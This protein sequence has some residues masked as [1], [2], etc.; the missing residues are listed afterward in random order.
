MG[1][2][3]KEGSHPSL[4]GRCWEAKPQNEVQ[5]VNIPK[6][7]ERALLM[8]QGKRNGQASACGREGYS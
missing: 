2:A 3:E 4:E 5:L 8:K 6:T 1:K 7:I